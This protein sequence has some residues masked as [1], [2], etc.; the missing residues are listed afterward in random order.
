MFTMDFAPPDPP[1]AV[2]V[3]VPSAG[4]VREEP[5]ITES[6][7]LAL[8][9]GLGTQYVLAGVQAAYYL[10]IPHSLYRVAPYVAV[11]VGACGGDNGVEC[12]IGA[13]V[14]GSWGHRHRLVV[15]LAYVPL[16][17][18]RFSFHGEAAHQFAVSGPALSIGYEYMG[19][20]GFCMRSGIG[21]GYLLGRPLIPDD[22]RLTLALTLFGLGYKFW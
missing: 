2:E 19:F 14:L 18:Y 6:D 22:Q 21:A 17:W 8:S 12:A 13:G 5:R 1:A 15:D 16:T 3:Q 9:A 4:A 10:Q 11:G 7:G 20:G